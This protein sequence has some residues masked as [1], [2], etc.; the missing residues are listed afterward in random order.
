MTSAKSIL[1]FGLGHVRRSRATG[2]ACI[3]LVLLLGTLAAAI[4][5]SR[6]QA[7]S[8]IQS[9]FALRGIASARFAANYLTEQSNRS[10][11]SAREFLSGATVSAHDF[12]LVAAT[13]N[14]SAAVLLDRSGRVLQSFPQLPGLRGQKIASGYPNLVKAEHGAVS[15][16]NLISS[17]VTDAALTSIAVPFATR[18]GRRVLSADYSASGL[19]LDA[20][21]AHTISY[22]EHNVYIVDSAGRLVASSPET[23]AVTLAQADP[24]LARSA[25]HATHGP[26]EG[27]AT[28]ST[29]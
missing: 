6:Q 1:T 7:K 11:R 23:N 3:A 25:A 15:T 13:L 17:P 14:S 29:F 22:P 20:L 28:P 16:S 26:V 27:S 5:L 19:A 12:E 8:Q 4:V 21:V 18:K 2:L 24:E 10:R 9:S